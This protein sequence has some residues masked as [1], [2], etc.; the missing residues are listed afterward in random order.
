MLANLNELSGGAGNRQNHK[1]LR[2]KTRRL[3]T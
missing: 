1:I 2:D 3:G